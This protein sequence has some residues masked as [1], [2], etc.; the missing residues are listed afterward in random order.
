MT[1]PRDVVE[2]D[3]LDSYTIKRSDLTH[4]AL[5]LTTIQITLDRMDIDS[6]KPGDKIALRYISKLVDETIDEMGGM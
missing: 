5:L 4:Y 1:R 3:R 6:I 2:S